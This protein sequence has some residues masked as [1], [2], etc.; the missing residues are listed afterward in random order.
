[1]RW[2]FALQSFNIEL[3][4]I[5]RSDN[6]IAAAL[7]CCWCWFMPFTHF[8]ISFPPQNQHLKGGVTCCP[9][10]PPLLV[11]PLGPTMHLDAIGAQAGGEHKRRRRE[12]GE[13]SCSCSRSAQARSPIRNLVGR[14]LRPWKSTDISPVMSVWFVNSPVFL[15]PLEQV[16]H[17]ITC[18]LLEPTCF[19][20]LVWACR[21]LEVLF[22]GLV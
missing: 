18:G 1:M 10:S 11:P 6:V 3:R 22:S 7:S 21:W 16:F 9:S 12:R 2:A 4:H 5:R 15:F 8:F 17:W 13:G 20:I 19:I 14:T